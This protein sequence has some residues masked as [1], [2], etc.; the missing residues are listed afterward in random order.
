MISKAL[1]GVRYIDSTTR[2]LRTGMDDITG[3]LTPLKVTISWRYME[4]VL[5]FSV[6]DMSRYLQAH[7]YRINHNISKRQLKEY[8][9]FKFSQFFFIFL[10][11]SINT[12]FLEDFY[13]LVLFL[14]PSLWAFC[15]ISCTGC[16]LMNVSLSD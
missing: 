16:E 11:S 9:L 2:A 13:F 1:C 15:L 5:C 7:G 10:H 3:F 4:F 12:A 6:T 8:L 14:P